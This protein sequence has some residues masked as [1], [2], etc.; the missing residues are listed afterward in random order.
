M[1]QT[2]QIH[3]FYLENHDFQVYVNKNIQTYGRTLDQE[4]QNPIT[5]EYYLSLQK[6]GCNA[7]SEDRAKDH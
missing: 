5:Q 4:L 2:E 1:I 7:K 6:G 3:R